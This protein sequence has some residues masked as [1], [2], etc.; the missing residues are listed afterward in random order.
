MGSDKAALTYEGQPQL[1]RAYDLLKAVC[2]QTFVSVR[3]DQSADATRAGLPQIIDRHRDLGPI[4]GIAAAQAQHPEA[5]WLVMACDLPFV[6]AA[7]LRYLVLHR[8]PHRLAT[9]F[10]SAHDGLPEPLCAI[11]EPSSGATVN[12]WIAAGKQCPRKLL[13]N[14]HAA[15]LDQ[16]EAGAL[17]NV[18]TLEEYTAA[19]N[20]LNRRRIQLHVQYF[21]IFREQAGTQRETVETRADTAAGLYEELRKKHAF[22]LAPS[23]L[24]VAINA[25]FRD[26]QSPLA[27]GDQVAFIPPVAGG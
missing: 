16:P 19:Q 8:D 25:E 14:S 20:A 12:A 5:A 2:E 10:R 6:S 3:A 26:W 7:T 1:K 9:V 17:D 4:A 24:K 22:K 11:W 27:D 21:A 18:N 23:Q 13:V 15:L